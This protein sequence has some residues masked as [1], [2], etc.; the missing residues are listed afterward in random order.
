MLPVN[1]FDQQ[2][3]NRRRTALFLVGF[4][5]FLAFLGLGADV[6]LYGAG[7][8]PGLP[9]FTLGAL[10]FGGLSAW[11]SLHEGDKAVLQSATARPADLNDPKERALDNV[12]EEM[13]IAAG[14]PK[15]R[16]FVIPD[17]DPNAFATGPGPEKSSI[18]VT[19]GLVDGL[20]REELQ[21]V[22]SHEMSH[23]RNYDIR[24]MTVVAALAGAVLLVSDWTRR[25]MRWGGLRGSRRDRGGGGGGLL[26]I[27]FLAVWILS[28]LL[29]PVIA[30]LVALAVS[31]EREYLADASGSEMT[32][33]PLALASALEK[34]DAAVAPTP[35]I[36]QGVAHL[37]I[38]DPRGRPVNEREGAWASLWATHPPIARRVALLR[39]MG[40]RNLRP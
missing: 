6:F 22:V 30:R 10:A 23:V 15:P 16:V 25:G 35:S 9:I 26:G 12:V 4:V 18:A 32:R 8:S 37:C 29:A 38:A 3:R 20:N 27:L 19:R 2:Q 36:K 39:E 40:Y 17:A 13:A 31:R 11:W 28:I 21:A 5:L 1:L 14:L 33:N 24:L 34:I 7:G